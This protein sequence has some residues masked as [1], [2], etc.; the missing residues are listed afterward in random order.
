[1]TKYRIYH[2]ENFYIQGIHAGIQ[3]YHSGVEMFVKYE[4]DDNPTV[5][6]LYDWA[7]NHKTVIVLNG[8]MAKD[9][10]ALETML[11]EAN[12][13]FPWASFREDV[14]AINGSITNVGIV[15]PDYIYEP[16][17]FVSKHAKGYDK[18]ADPKSIVVNNDR[19]LTV[20]FH[21]DDIKLVN[22]IY[23]HKEVEFMKIL[24]SCRLMS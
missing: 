16:A 13:V 9:L 14:D 19:S 6:M 18:W 10:I 2:F 20:S 17:W 4:N 11:T 15:L 1:M 23:K 3:S 22:K 5:K 8:G 12:M 7:R 24:A 21:N